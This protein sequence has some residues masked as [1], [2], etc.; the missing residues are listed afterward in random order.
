MPQSYR[1]ALLDGSQ[2]RCFGVKSNWL[3]TIEKE[4][5][6]LLW[7]GVEGCNWFNLGPKACLFVLS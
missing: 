6:R 2:A 3:L 4:P 1:T 7:R 5:S